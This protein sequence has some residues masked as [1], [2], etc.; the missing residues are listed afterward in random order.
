[1]L[2][3]LELPPLRLG[4][5]ALYPFSVL[6]V[7]SIAVGYV[8][9]ARRCVRSGS[10]RGI[11][12]RLFVWTMVWGLAGAHS[13]KIL[14]EEPAA[15]RQDPLLFFRVWEGIYSFGGIVVL[16]LDDNVPLWPR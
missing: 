15:L 8:L 13:L 9:F 7:L 3:Y 4:P 16:Y 5:V 10:H 12:R 1:M 2:P 6:L 14:L 11:A